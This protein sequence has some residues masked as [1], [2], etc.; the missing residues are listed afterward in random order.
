MTAPLSIKKVRPWRGHQG[1]VNARLDRVDIE[2]LTPPETPDRKTF[3][4]NGPPEW[5]WLEADK[6]LQFISNPSEFDPG[7]D[8]D[9]LLVEN[10]LPFN[11]HLNSYTNTFKGA[12]KVKE[13]FP[14]QWWAHDVWTRRDVVSY[15]LQAAALTGTSVEQIANEVLAY[16]EQVWWYEKMFFDVRPY[17]NDRTW[18]YLHVFQP[19]VMRF[20]PLH[21]QDF[22]WKALAYD[23]NIDW[24]TMLEV[25]NP[26]G[27]YPD[28]AKH[29]VLAMLDRKILKDTLLAVFGRIPNRYNEN[30]IVDQYIK[31]LEIEGGGEFGGGGDR[32]K[33]DNLMTLM[34][35]IQNSFRMADLD[36]TFDGVEKRA[37][38]K[39]VEVYQER[40]RL[41]AEAERTDLGDVK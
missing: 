24:R 21:T 34:S 5:R 37:H 9:P 31:M 12:Q 1:P 4:S 6:I 14:D 15:F 27:A 7:R 19:A 26:M 35:V 23:G 16:P 18:I 38:E 13:R 25:A 17:L 3:A 11:W 32:D 33:E 40:K 8:I 29:R 30:Y 28:D 10:V 20:G 39:L 41:V 2:D 36:N 22:L